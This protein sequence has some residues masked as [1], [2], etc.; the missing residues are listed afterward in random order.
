MLKRSLIIVAITFS[1]IVAARPVPIVHAFL[2]TGELE[3]V[4]ATAAPQGSE[5][6]SK[7][8]NGFV[9]VLKAPFKAIGRIFGGGNDDKLRRISEKDA[10]KFESGGVLRVVDATIVPARESAGSKNNPAPGQSDTT[11][12]KEQAD[13][14]AARQNVAQARTLMNE[15]K[16]N[17]AL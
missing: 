15:G 3:T 13:K 11:P 2:M 7:D 9:R 5:K 14:I 17:E 1:L 10:K 4:D 12:T 8:G 6:K 16:E